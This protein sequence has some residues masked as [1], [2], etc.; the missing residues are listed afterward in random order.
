MM[1]R[2]G[3]GVVA[4]LLAL[5]GPAR[6]VTPVLSDAL[7]VLKAWRGRDNAARP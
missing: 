1:S 5:A 3:A 6:S 4:G 7:A 2:E